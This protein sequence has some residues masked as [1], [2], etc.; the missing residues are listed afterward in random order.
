MVNGAAAVAVL[1]D[2]CV[3]YEKT[4]ICN[5]ILFSSW[6][7]W[8]LIIISNTTSQLNTH[9][10]KH[11]HTHTVTQTTHLNSYHNNLL[12]T[13]KKGKEVL[14][15][16]FIGTNDIKIDRKQIFFHFFEYHNI[17]VVIIIIIIILSSIIINTI[18]FPCP[19]FDKVCCHLLSTRVN[20][21]FKNN[22]SEIL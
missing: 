6:T 20:E 22:G 15:F 10:Y 18:S 12:T 2:L 16:S 7:N 9:T 17:I 13:Q 11:T 1:M 5:F 4:I 19:L 3:Y 14:Y 21:I 8:L